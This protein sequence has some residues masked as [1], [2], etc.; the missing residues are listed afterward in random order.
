MPKHRRSVSGAVGELLCALRATVR[1]LWRTPGFAL[2]VVLTLALGIGANLAIFQLLNAVPFARLPI[3]APEQLYSL[4]A[5]KSPFDRQWFFSYPAYRNL[6]GATA[7]TAAVIA[8]SGMSGGILQSSQGASERVDVQ[9]V[10][11]N[12]FDVLGIR[13]A[14]GRFFWPS[15]ENPAQGEWPGVLR[16][17]YW[18]QSLGGDATAVGKHVVL[19]GV[20]LVIVGITPERFSGVVAGEAPDVWLPLA[21]Q[22]TE[23]FPSWFDSLGPGSGAD[24][25]ASYLNQHG[26]F[27][28]WLLARVPSQQ[29]TSAEMR[30][31]AAL[32]PDLALI[33]NFSKEARNREQILQSRVNLVSAAS[34]EGTLREEYGQPLTVLMAMAGLV[35]L[36]GAVNLANLQLARLLG[37]Q[38]ELAVRT[39]LG[40]S[41]WQILCQLLAEDLVLA[42]I[43]TALAVPVGQAACSLLLEWASRSGKALPLNLQIGWPQFAFVALLLIAV[44]TGFSL[45]PASRIARSNLAANMTLRSSSLQGPG[46]RSW[47][48][49]LLAGQVSFSLLLVGTAALFA[50]TLLNLSRIDAGLDRDHVLSVH[51]DFS[52]T[53]FPEKEWRAL[54][55]R[56]VTRIKE[57]PTVIDAAAQMCA[58]PGCIW[59]TAIH[60][61]GH[62]EIPESQLHGEENRV[63]QHYFNTM[64]IPILQGR[65]FDER[66]TPESQPVVIVNHTF[67]RQLFGGRSPIGHRIGY[68]PAPHDT[69]FVIVGEAADARVDDLRSPPPGVVYGSLSQRPDPVDTIE[70]RTNGPLGTT[71]PAIRQSLLSLDPSI[72]ITEIVPLSQEYDAGLSREKLLAKLTGIF[73]LLALAIAALG[74]YGLLSFNFT[75]RAAE[76]AVRM[77][78]G[79][80]PAD[81]RFLVLRQ[82]FGI[83]IVG[84]VPGVILTET[85]GRIA[86]GLLYGSATI[87]V[88]ALSFAIFVLVCVGLVAALLPARR[89]ARID[90]LKTLH[91]E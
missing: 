2:T 38:R 76:I 22:S 67:A 45:I 43:G 20:P 64:A 46:V 8:R 10:S 75:R 7:S 89:A 17:G 52:N 62:P 70:V 6:R 5:V 85:M 65:D 28:V 33:A 72:P 37:R 39:S 25:R 40:A 68:Q 42:L 57:L 53:H 27:W 86:R 13:P 3:L 1:P 35:L 16:Y 83:L 59:N 15:D 31:S 54:S 90:P 44:L 61:A 9:M 23:N 18:K 4:R 19:N 21:A 32:Q 11:D 82:T 30:W 60:V 69:E 58:I 66:D 47:S 12:F 71:G 80:T 48:N 78:I 74:F 77:A 91:A 84:I 29:K 36:V 24:I 56:M 14:A 26:V 79:A 41:Q 73:G 50:Q 55:D 87:D 63:G 81:V 51:F 88:W 49:L 34:G